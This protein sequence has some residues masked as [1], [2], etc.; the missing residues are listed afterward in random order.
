MSKLRQVK[1]IDYDANYAY[2]P[3]ERD[4]VINLDEIVSVVAIER[5]ATRR[6]F[7]DL[8][9]IRFRDGSILDVIGKPGDFVEQSP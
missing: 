7:D 5:G 2:S 4:A 8:V 3:P 9:R 1:F 6:A